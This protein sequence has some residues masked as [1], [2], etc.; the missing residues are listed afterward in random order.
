MKSIRHLFSPS[1]PPRS[2][3]PW[4]PNC[5]KSDHFLLFHYSI[6]YIPGFFLGRVEIFIFDSEIAQNLQKCSSGKLSI[7][8]IQ[9]LDYLFAWTDRCDF[10]RD[11][12]ILF[13]DLTCSPQNEQ[14]S[15]PKLHRLTLFDIFRC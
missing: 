13:Y 4:N 15:V 8:I 14:G 9:R 5:F 3:P 2:F 11:S 10:G 6:N 7:I 12:G 1:P